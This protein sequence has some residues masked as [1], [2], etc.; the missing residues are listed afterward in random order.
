MVKVAGALQALG[1]EAVHAWLAGTLP[2]EVLSKP[3]SEQAKLLPDPTG[4]V[5]DPQP[6]V[7]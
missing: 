1:R 4:K 5:S 3:S 2:A 7:C 6:R